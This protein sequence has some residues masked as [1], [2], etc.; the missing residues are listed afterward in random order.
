[1]ETIILYIGICVVGVATGVLLKK[2]HVDIKWSGKVQTA[3]LVVLLFTMGARLG[4]NRDVMS[5]LD[6]IGIISF[7]ITISIMVFS[8]LGIF[9]TRKF[10]GFDKEGKRND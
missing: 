3:M 9:L 4:S 2:R 5:K 7:V 8:V 6:S 1:M 10:L